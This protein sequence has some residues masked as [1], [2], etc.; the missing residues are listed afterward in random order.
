MTTVNTGTY[1]SHWMVL[2]ASKVEKSVGEKKL[3]PKTFYY[4][5][6]I[7]GS[8]K[9]QDATDALNKNSYW[10]SYNIPFV[11]EHQNAAGYTKM[12]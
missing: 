6:Q 1:N 3:E 7:P 12:Y 10:A 11:K 4:V 9:V 8:I 5:E 2:D